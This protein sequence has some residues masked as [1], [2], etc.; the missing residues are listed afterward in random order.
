MWIH[1][2]K[3]LAIRCIAFVT[4]GAPPRWGLCAHNLLLVI[5]ARRSFTPH[6]DNFY[7]EARSLLF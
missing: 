2:S 3:K 4:E 5:I 7:F 1:S 6:G